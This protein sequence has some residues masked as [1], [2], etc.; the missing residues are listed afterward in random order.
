MKQQL[1]SLD[2][3]V[4]DGRIRVEN[5]EFMKSQPPRIFKWLRID[6]NDNCNL[7]CTY[8]RIPRSSSLIDPVEL[9]TFLREKVVSVESLQFGCGM[10]PT[11]DSRLA[12]VM[13]MAASTPAQPT[14][15]FVVQTNGTKLHKHD[16]QKMAAAGLTRLSVSIDSLNEDV[17]A[18]QRGGSSV[19]Q[20]IANLEEFR[21]HCP[22]VEIQF[23]CVVTKASIGCC[24]DLAEFAVSLGA[25][26]VA[27]REMMHVANDAITDPAKVAPLIVPPGEFEAM[28][29]SVQ[30]RFLD[31]GTHFEFLPINQ[32]H[33]TRFEMRKHVFPENKHGTWQRKQL[34]MPPA[35]NFLRSANKPYLIPLD[36]DSENDVLDGKQFFVLRGAMKS[37]LNWVERLLNLHPEISC[38]GEFHW[39]NLTAPFIKNIDRSK[40]LSD[41]T[42]LRHEM[43]MRLDRMMKECIV[44]ANHPNATWVGDRTP[45]HISPS[46]VMGSKIIN[47]VRDGRDVLVSRMHQFFSSENSYPQLMHQK[48]N[49]RRKASFRNNPQFFLNHPEELLGCLD[50]VREFGKSWATAIVANGQV[51]REL[52]DDRCL[53]IHYET[54]H[55]DTESAR[56]ILYDFLGVDPS[57]AGPLA[58]TTQAGFEQE[59]PNQFLRKGAVGDWKNYM[60]PA[61]KQAFNEV[62]G[63]ALIEAGYVKSLDW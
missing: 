38:A 46:V 24:E 32:L 2:A 10:E 3:P 50:C 59:T 26:R 15:R 28:T 42:G 14:V 11:V 60:T 44:L 25:T 40:L 30:A 4:E 17:H 7:K 22:D 57:L 18:F 16:H 23:I 31:Q 29:R 47:L 8:C 54:I 58:R 61:A 19:K 45:V 5:F 12:D 1:H 51:T 41:K 33:Q 43:W 48:E 63:E 49:S 55:R 62:A 9:E 39:Q 36:N 35:D 34:E 20:I 56:T 13:Q 53:K 6:A 37:G 21:D 27:F 52:D